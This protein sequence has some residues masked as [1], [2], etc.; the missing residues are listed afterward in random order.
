MAKKEFLVKRDVIYN[1]KIINV[2]N[3]LIKIEGTEIT[4]NREIV[5]HNGGVCAVV[6]TKEGKIK[7]VRQF[8]YAF[9]EFTIEV[10]AGKI[11]RGEGPDYTILRELEEEVGVKAKSIK[12]IGILYPS[13][14]FSQEVL[15]LYY[16]DDYDEV[17]SHFD[18]DEDLDSFELTYSEALKKIEDGEIVDAKTVAIILRVRDYFLTK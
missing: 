1:G 3:D 18:Y 12:K 9:N 15:H 8:R 4:S 17:K 11:E 2:Y 10:P 7:F 13:P 6:K 5:N 14:G 16:T